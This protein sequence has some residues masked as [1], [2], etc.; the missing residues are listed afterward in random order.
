LNVGSSKTVNTFNNVLAEG[1]KAFYLIDGLAMSSQSNTDDSTVRGTKINFH[2]VSE[3]VGE[4]TKVSLDRDFKGIEE[5]IKGFIEQY[6]SVMDFIEEKSRVNVKDKK[7]G[8]KDTKTEIEDKGVFSGD[9]TV[10]RL[11]QEIQIL[12]TSAIPELSDKTQY[13]SL[14]RVGIT[15]NSTTGHLEIDSDDLKKALQTDF[16]GVRSLFVAQGVSDNNLHEMGKYTDDTVAGSYAFDAD[17]DTIDGVKA[18]RIGQV[19][20]SKSG[21]SNGLSIKAPTGT[22]VGT[23]SFT[24]GLASKLDM[25]YQQHNDYVDGLFKQTK[26]SNEKRVRDYEVKIED[27]WDKVESFKSRLVKQFSDMEQ[28]MSRLQ[29]QSSSFMSAMSKV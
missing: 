17:N 15:T 10:R 22:G 25:L 16:E 26:D 9:S 5:R 12:M 18:T 1:Q 8:E 3:N 11:K 23:L 19:L 4:P 24:R 2:K 20:I 6:N 7:E 21:D 27:L 29:S 14:S 28:S 13:T